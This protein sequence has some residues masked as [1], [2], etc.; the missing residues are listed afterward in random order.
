MCGTDF[1][2]C[3]FAG[4]SFNEAQLPGATFRDCILSELYAPVFTAARSGLRDFDWAAGFGSS[5]PSGT[6]L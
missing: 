6:D 3:G 5:T 1:A 4:A 2:E